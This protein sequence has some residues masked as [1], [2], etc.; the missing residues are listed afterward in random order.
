[1]REVILALKRRDFF[2]SITTHT[3]SKEWQDVYHGK[4]PEGVAVYIKVTYFL[5]DRP[6]IIQFKEK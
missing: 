4:T 6:P 1:M 3:D 5:D 2:K